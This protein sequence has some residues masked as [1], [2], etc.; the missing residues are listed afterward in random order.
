MELTLHGHNALVTGAN[1]GLGRHFAQTLA[2]AGA[3]VAIAARRVD[4]ATGTHTHL[5]VT[6]ARADLG[7]RADRDIAIA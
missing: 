5:A 3:R 2:A 6:A 1:G 7:R 4:G